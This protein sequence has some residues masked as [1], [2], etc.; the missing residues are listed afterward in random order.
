MSNAVKFVSPGTRPRVVV[1]AERQGGVVRLCIADNGIGVPREYQGRLFN[2]FERLHPH[3]NY[4][5]TGIGLAIVRKAVERMNGK[6]GM[7]SL[8]GG[9]SCFWLELPTPPAT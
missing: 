1:S 4:E 3:L 2:M 9:G 5:G 6:V 7:H 8:D